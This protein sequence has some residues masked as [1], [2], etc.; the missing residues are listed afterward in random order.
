MGEVAAGAG[1]VD[2]RGEAARRT[3]PRRSTAS[4]PSSGRSWRPTAAAR[5]W[6]PTIRARTPAPE[7]DDAAASRASEAQGQARRA[8]DGAPPP[9]PPAA[10]PA[11]SPARRASI[12]PTQAIA[13][14]EKAVALRP[15][16]A[17]AMTYLGLVWRQKSFG[18]FA[19]PAAWQQAVDRANEWQKRAL[20]RAGRE[21]LTMAFEAFRA[22]SE[23]PARG[24]PQA[25][26]VRAVDRAPRRADRRRHRVFVL[27]HRGAVAAAAQGDVPVGGPAAAR[28]RRRRPRAA[29]RR[30]KKVDVKPKTVVQP[31]PEIVQPKEIPKKEQSR[32]RSRSPRTIT[33][34]RRA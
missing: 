29:A 19:E 16:Y 28:R 7:D 12:S 17:D 4:A 14:L 23:A 26:L 1:V 6:P 15:H 8:R 25:A 3:T 9:P 34:R 24:G 20:R 18:L 21:E 30:K 31:K 13:H 5:T 22:Q 32:R 11:T 33:A 10:C 2:A 27:A